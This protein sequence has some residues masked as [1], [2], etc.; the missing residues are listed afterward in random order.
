MTVEDWDCR[1]FMFTEKNFLRYYSIATFTLVCTKFWSEIPT[2]WHYSPLG[3]LRINSSDCIS[4][5]SISSSLLTVHLKWRP[6]VNSFVLVHNDTYLTWPHAS[7]A[8]SCILM[9]TSIAFF[10]TLTLKLPH[11]LFSTT[12]YVCKQQ[13]VWCGVVWCGV[14]RLLYLMKPLDMRLLHKEPRTVQTQV[15][16]GMKKCALVTPH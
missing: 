15:G 10:S 14:E 7:A 11:F 12:T 2:L 9:L 13:M 16:K 5:R 1:L 3:T 4:L 6:N 8:T